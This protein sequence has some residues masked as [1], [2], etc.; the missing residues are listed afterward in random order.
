MAM[1]QGPVEMLLTRPSAST[2]A[3]METDRARRKA[4]VIA[5]VG[6]ATSRGRST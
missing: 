6:A 1:A 4:H 3:A 5:E 2:A